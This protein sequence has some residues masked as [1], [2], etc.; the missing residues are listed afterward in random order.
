MDRW[1]PG[2]PQQVH[3]QALVLLSLAIALIF[4]FALALFFWT[5]ILRRRN[6]RKG[7]I[8]AALEARWRD[9]LLDLLAEGG[10][11]QSL[12]RSVEKG[13]ELYFVDFLLRYAKQLRGS[14]METVADLARPYLDSV[15]RHVDNKETE[16]R[17]RAVYTLGILALR[18]PATTAKF[19]PLVVRALD[20]PT[21][22]VGMVALR[23]LARPECQAYLPAL[24]PRLSHFQM[25]NRRFLVSVLAG[26][27]GQAAG[28]LRVLM[29]NRRAPLWDR[30][31][32]A[33]ALAELHDVEA[34]D[35]AAQ[36][37]AEESDRELLAALLRLLAGI[38]RPEHLPAVRALAGAEDFVVRAHVATALGRLGGSAEHA[39]LRQ[40]LDDESNWVA[41]RAALAL[42]EAGGE[43]LLREAAGSPH[44]RA[45][46]ARQ[47]LAEAT[48]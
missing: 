17:A 6:R 19:A 28:D 25:M 12:L 8:W 40:L 10:S 44:P 38:G 31:L 21:P 15:A 4:V 30:G 32:A 34:G 2:S 24:L 20:D 18:Q 33:D 14:E 23:A 16:R 7:E 11:H 29:G 1:L 27:G 41:H 47:A 37:L 45:E 48:R 22:L 46:M 36:V 39:L 42:H 9:Q 13:Q 3:H 26:V 5:L 35:A 43:A